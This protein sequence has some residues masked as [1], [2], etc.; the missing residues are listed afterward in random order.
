M[1]KEIVR[2]VTPTGAYLDP[3]ANIEGIL[4]ASPR[5]PIRLARALTLN[6]PLVGAA[7]I[8]GGLGLIGHRFGPEIDRLLSPMFGGKKSRR[9]ESEEEINERRRMW[10]YTLAGIGGLGFLSTQF[11]TKAPGYGLLSYRPM[12]KEASRSMYN[13]LSI[14]DSRDLILGSRDLSFDAKQNALSLLRT[15]D[16]PPTTHIGGGDVIG[17]A[18]ATGI[19]GMKGAAIG[20]I[21]AK[22]PGLPNP[23]S[24]AI[25]G[26][27]ANIAGVKPAMA[28][29]VIFGN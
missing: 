27:V 29:S 25:L 24:T 12:G 4:N 2:N 13:T 7:A 18:V 19:S 8:A 22:A 28:T 20:F 11:S 21:T 10:G 15:F 6:S 9:S 14:Q 3:S 17:Q 5:T 26:A 1:N 16:A 23:S